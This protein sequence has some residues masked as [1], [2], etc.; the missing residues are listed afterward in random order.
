MSQ[1]PV[2]RC[3]YKP[4][5]SSTQLPG[6][7]IL[8]CILTVLFELFPNT[9][10]H[11]ALPVL[12]GLLHYHIPL[13]LSVCWLRVMQREGIKPRWR[14]GCP[15]L[16]GCPS[17]REA[18]WALQEHLAKGRWEALYAAPPSHT[19]RQRSTCVALGSI[20]TGSKMGSATANQP[21]PKHI[22]VS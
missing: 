21:R 13:A 5:R 3:M 7:R 14:S 8:F 6:S 20:Q 15:F 22:Y 1:E 10:L 2:W 17:S 18:K 11:T 4:L 19:D 12:K 16:V 9:R